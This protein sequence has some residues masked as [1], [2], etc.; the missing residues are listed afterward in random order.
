MRVLVIGAG[1]LGGY[2]GGCLVRAGRDVTFLVRPR[3]AEQLAR[4]ALQIASPNGDFRVSATT[5]LA[6][7]LREPFD[8]ILVGVKSYSL[9]DAMEQFAAAVGPDTAI[10]PILNGIGHFDRLSARFGAEHILG[11]MANISAGMDAEGRVV[12][13]FPNH[14][15]V[16]GEIRGGSSDRTRAI[17]DCFNNAGFNGRPSGVVMLD[18][19]E[20]FVQ[21]G[22]GAGITCLM[23]ASIGDILAAPGGREAMFQIFGEC[24]AVA[25]ASGFM[26]RPAFIEF[27]TTLITTVGSPLKWSML[28]DIERGSTTEGEHI[29]G[30]MV[31]RARALGVETPILNLARTHVAAYEIGRARAAAA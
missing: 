25:T 23:R 31:A 16:F 10:L 22:L 6:G 30:D 2:F 17:E 7:D 4:D 24:C 26:P 3:R 11:G 5:V 20:K 9:D 1:A 29:L 8:L 21:L 14:D 15:L 19:W 28:R 18:M 13:F 12:Q 27:D